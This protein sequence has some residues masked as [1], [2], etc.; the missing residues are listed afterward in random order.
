MLGRASSRPR[1]PPA[2]AS[3]PALADP[4]SGQPAVVFDRGVVLAVCQNLHRPEMRRSGWGYPLP[5]PCELPAA[6]Q[7]AQRLI[8]GAP[9]LVV[10]ADRLALGNSQ[11]RAIAVVEIVLNGKSACSP[12][13]AAAIRMTTRMRPS[14]CFSRLPRPPSQQPGMQ[15]AQRQRRP[16]RQHRGPETLDA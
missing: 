3:G 4:E 12:S 2:E 6:K 5:G 9:Q 8:V 14:A 11:R 10:Q 16:C 15:A 1:R 7:L 13:F